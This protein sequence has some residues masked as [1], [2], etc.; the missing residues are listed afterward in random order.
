MN[1]QE[2]LLTAFPFILS[3]L[4][5]FGHYGLLVTQNPQ[6]HSMPLIPALL[7]QTLKDSELVPVAPLAPFPKTIVGYVSD[8]PTTKQQLAKVLGDVK[9]NQANTLVLRIDLSLTKDGNLI[10][11]HAAETSEEYILRWA[12]KTVR[13]AHEKGIYTYLIFMPK[14]GTEI[15]DIGG[16]AD[17]L[18]SLLERWAPAAEEHHVAFLD[19]GIILGHDSLRKVPPEYQQLLVKTIEQKIRAMYTG[20]IGL[21]VCCVP[22]T[23]SSQGHNQLVL[24]AQTGDVPKNIEL[25]TLQDAKRYHVEHVFSLD[26]ATNRLTQL[27]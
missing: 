2:I 10:V 5:I 12:K 22:P 9:A 23:V 7:I 25:K 6:A 19:P 15:A 21:G 27:K 11:I 17:Q 1:R 14:D 24:I 8:V 3:A 20:R 4:L 16:F 26:L 13:D 18:Q